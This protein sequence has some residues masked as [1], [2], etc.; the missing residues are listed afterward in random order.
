[1]QDL[2]PFRRVLR[3]WKSFSCMQPTV[4]VTSGDFQTHVPKLESPA[5]H[6]YLLLTSV[7]RI[8]IRSETTADEPGSN[9]RVSRVALRRDNSF[10]FCD[11]ARTWW[12]TTQ[13]SKKFWYY[14]NQINSLSALTSRKVGVMVTWSRLWELEEMQEERALHFLQLSRNTGTNNH[15]KICFLD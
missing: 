4:V 9:E 11:S 8:R 12:P 5:M 7:F 3:V 14:S 6:T 10:T 15:R 2:I 13:F 1:M